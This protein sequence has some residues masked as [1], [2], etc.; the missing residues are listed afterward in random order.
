MTAANVSQAIGSELPPALRKAQ[1]AIHRPEVQAMLRRL[2]DYGLGIFMPHQ[3]D[4]RTGEFEPLDDDHMQVESGCKVSF[5][6]K[7]RIA[8]RSD[9]FLPVA[10]R[11]QAGASTPASVCEMAM[12]E[13]PDGAEVPVQ[14]KMPEDDDKEPE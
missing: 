10:W 5:Q 12:E 3:H 13:G 14:H 4:Q 8:S 7:E 11:W 1:A 6:R 9:R 2:S